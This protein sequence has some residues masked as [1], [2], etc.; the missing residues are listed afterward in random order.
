MKKL[1]SFC[2]LFLCFCLISVL[3]ADE[4]SDLANKVVVEGTAD[5]SK[6]KI[7][8]RK[9]SHKVMAENNAAR[10]VHVK[11]LISVIDAKKEV[12]VKSYLI[13]ELQYIG[14]Q[15]SIAAVSKYLNHKDL[16]EPATQTLIGIYQ[17]TKSKAIK[18]A[19]ATAFAQASTANELTLAKACG[20]VRADDSATQSKL[21]ELASNNDWNVRQVALQ[22]LAAMGT[23]GCQ[24]LFASSIKNSKTS[25]RSFSLKLNFLYARR[26]AG[27][28]KIAAI[29]LCKSFILQ[30][31]EQKDAA[32]LVDCLYSLL[33]I[34]T[35]ASCDEIIKYLEHPN[36]R[37]SKSL[38]RI[39]QGIKD[40]NI[41]SKLLSLLHSGTTKSKTSALAILLKNSPKEV[42]PSI[43]TFLSS[44]DEALKKAALKA[45][46]QLDAS[47]AA[48]FLLKALLK[49]SDTD[50][51]LAQTT[52]AQLAIDKK[53]TKQV[54]DAYANES[55]INN[56]TALIN[57]L[58]DN[59][60]KGAL[61]TILKAANEGNDDLRKVAIKALKTT[62]QVTDV[63]DLLSFLATVESKEVRYVQYGLISAFRGEQSAS[64]ISLLINAAAKL[65]EKHQ[66]AVFST[67]ASIEA[68][69]AIDALSGY[70]LSKNEGVQKAAIK[71]LSGSPSIF[72]AEILANACAK[73]SPTNRILAARGV[74][75]LVDSIEGD[76]LLKK[77]AMQKALPNVSS[78]AEK[79]KLKKAIENIHAVYNMALGKNA[80]ASK[81]SKLEMLT[82]G[83]ITKK[84]VANISGKDAWVQIDLEKLEPV[85]AVGITF[86]YDGK[87]HY[88]YD[89]EVSVDNKKWQSVATINKNIVAKESGAVYHFT[90]TKA[91]YFRVSKIISTRISGKK[92]SINRSARIAEFAVYAAGE[93][94]KKK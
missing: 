4:T 32:Y 77:R 22:S 58:A 81:G 64:E 39:L 2:T 36:P 5:D 73:G 52:F 79:T 74:M 44:N 11:S 18:A 90:P 53:T 31:Q 80:T 59:S 78:D 14:R 82:D 61:K 3:S 29:D 42:T 8:L 69:T 86:Y 50:K 93:S 45:C 24:D 34:D 43:V 41:D 19:I 7:A 92:K 10:L 1:N 40:K 46:T 28:D 76:N 75:Q 62:T 67:L 26:M 68:K 35:A 60:I 33:E 23:P 37:I 9:L 57:L 84:A 91:R 65:N 47:E 12:E 30:L 89:I 66:A 17:N 48:P 6:V 16:C 72:A 85:E 15:E 20:A 13:R 49:G 83:I 38:E 56:K 51:K 94:P 63:I 70:A 55:S 54:C 25:A 27:K 88:T 87:T 21:K 71:A